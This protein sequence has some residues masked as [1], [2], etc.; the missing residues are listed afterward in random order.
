M[1]KMRLAAKK[2]LYTHKVSIAKVKAKLKKMGWESVA[3]QTKKKNPLTGIVDLVAIRRSKRNP[4]R[5]QIVFFQVKGGS[6]RLTKKERIRLQR[7]IK[8]FEI[9]YDYACYKRGKPVELTWNPEEFL[10]KIKLLR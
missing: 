8:T 1:N 7:S 5:L 3:F 4:N 6:A 9:G 10:T 2:A